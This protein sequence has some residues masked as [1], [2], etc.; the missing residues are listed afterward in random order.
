MCKGFEPRAAT[1]S[2]FA[3]GP[4]PRKSRWAKLPHDNFTVLFE[5]RVEGKAVE[6]ANPFQNRFDIFPDHAIGIFFRH[7]SVRG[8]P[9]DG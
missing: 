6:C 3:I 7:Q 5:E 4:K 8:R 2:L 9:R 1:H